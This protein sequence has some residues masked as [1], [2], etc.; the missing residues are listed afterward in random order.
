MFLLLIM[1]FTS[2]N[3]FCGGFMS[4]F[5]TDNLS[6]VYAASVT[7]S[8]LFPLVKNN[9]SEAARFSEI[10]NAAIENAVREAHTE[11]EWTDVNMSTVMTKL[12]ASYGG[13]WTNSSGFNYSL[14][15]MSADYTLGQLVV[16]YTRATYT[17]AALLTDE[18][19]IAIFNRMCEEHGAPFFSVD[20][21]MTL[22]TGEIN[23]ASTG[24]FANRSADV[25][26]Y[27]ENAITYGQYILKRNAD[28]KGPVPNGTLFIGTWI[29][30]AKAVNS[31][32]YHMA[33]DSLG[34]HNQTNRLYKSELSSGYWKEIEGG[35]GLEE[36]L[37]LSD[38]VSE[39]DMLDLNVTVE[40]DSKGIAR[41]AKNG[42]EINVFDI[43]DPYELEKIPE[44]KPL[45]TMY[46]NGVVSATDKGPKN[47]TYWELYHFFDDDQNYERRPEL[48]TGAEYVLDVSKRGNIAFYAEDARMARRF[49]ESGRGF[50]NSL[51]IDAYQNGWGWMHYN[52]NG[53]PGYYGKIWYR[54]KLIR[55]SVSWAGER[56]WKSE[57]ERFPKGLDT[58]NDYFS[59]FKLVWRHKNSIHDDVTDD[60]D[61]KLR[62]LYSNYTGF[63][64]SISSEDRE[65]AEAIIEIA[66]KLDA[67]RRYHAYYNLVENPENN[68][69]IGPS[70]GYLYEAVSKGTTAV[71][72]DYRIVWYT[73]EDFTA[74]ESIKSAVETAI[75]DCTNTMNNYLG[76]A[77]NPGTTVLS[78][79]LYNVEEQVINDARNG[80][81]NILRPLLRQAVDLDNISKNVIA[82]KSRELNLIVSTLLPT[83]DSK[84]LNVLHEGASSD[85]RTAAADPSTTA[86]IKNQLLNDQK[87]G[88]SSVAAEVQQLV[89][90]RAIRLNNGQAINFVKD[91]INWAEA[92]RAGIASDDFKS[93]ATQ[94]LDEHIQWLTDLLNQLKAGGNLTNDENDYQSQL[95]GI[96]KDI[97]D[98]LDNGDLDGADKLLKKADSTKKNQDSAERKKRQ[99]INDP[100]ASAAD[101]AEALDTTTPTGIADDIANSAISKIVDGETGGIEDD[102]AALEDLGSDRLPDVLA[103]LEANNGSKSLINRTKKAIADSSTDF[104]DRY[105]TSDNGGGSGTNGTGGA[106]GDGTNENDSSDDS[107]GL[108]GETGGIAGKPITGPGNGLDDA[109]IKDAIKNVMGKDF[110]KLS[111]ADKAAAVTGLIHFASARNDGDVYNSLIELLK[112]LKDE[113]NVFIYR[114][115]VTD[116]SQE[117]VSLAAVNRAR[118][119]TRYRL[120]EKEGQYTMSQIAGGT[121]SYVFKVGDNSVKKNNGS[122]EKMETPL[123]SQSDSY[124]YGDK[125]TLYPYLSEEYAGKYLYCT[126]VYV[127]GT[128]WAVLITPQTDKKIAQ[129]MDMLDLYLENQ[130]Q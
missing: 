70:L 52:W 3:G 108:E 106:S 98:A 12:S 127:P 100:D 118:R 9:L 86:E 1:L 18:Q 68:Y 111:D 92:Q 76:N 22:V 78:Q 16:E 82:H 40:V 23:N 57:V 30:D 4:S 123:R 2:F 53:H 5:I 47:Y 116:Q 36:I 34:T 48:K 71:G 59:W 122:K 17:G 73:D 21:Y 119:Y 81:L 67:T 27:D 49:E 126:C 50:L 75:T 44:L 41:W 94:A 6:R 112:Q 13:T 28:G 29:M 85:Y 88:V 58:L 55:G 121:S 65:M 66:D 11:G 20:D 15:P 77:R 103:A 10:N 42:Q 113:R 128:E 43:Y 110:D 7:E 26:D 8:I 45:Y 61:E 80:N 31:V 117:Y 54:S 129:L 69:I 87:A 14:N 101:K 32:F 35:G 63:C 37:P 25:M 89:Y 115:Y 95:D 33:V 62:Y 83:A 93:K 64:K 79:T 96:T 125:K 124:L 19:L 97:L 107:T 104:A 114:Q 91:R 56:A 51:E 24:G 120:V 109:A 38:N 60:A 99:I 72:S 74:E 105:G 84:F 102:I 46:K 39:T 90:A 130:K